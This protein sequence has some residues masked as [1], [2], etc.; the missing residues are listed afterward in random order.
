MNTKDDRQIV[1]RGSLLT[2]EPLAKY[3]TWRVGGNARVLYKPKGL[4][5][6]TNFFQLTPKTEPLLMLGLGSNSLIKDEGFNGI[7]VL[8]RGTL[9]GIE[10]LDSD[11]V[12]T[13]AGV[14]CATMARFTARNN[15]GGGEFWA[16]I[17]G[18]MGGALRMNAGCFDGE[19]WNFVQSVETITRDGKIHVRF[20]EE[21]DISYRS[22]NGLAPDEYF[23]AA[24]FKLRQGNKDNSLKKIKDLLD[25]RAKTQPTSDFNC[26]SVFRNPPS[27]FAAQLIESCGLKGISI[28][29]AM[30]S[31]KHAN[32]IINNQ[33]T[34]RALDIYNLISHVQKT[35]FEKTEIS[36]VREV[37]IIG[38]T[39]CE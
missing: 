38:D 11:T 32:F 16:G 13:E 19:T 17:P 5:D 21:F 34:A 10:L 33:G 28:G 39:S 36:L 1:L 31:D 14:S 18:T 35:V 3:T 22:V 12:R 37:H 2:N 20:P 7:V 25:R 24:T 4:D 27:K 8:T 30:V 29:G 15:L 9:S 26:G 23:V 6:L